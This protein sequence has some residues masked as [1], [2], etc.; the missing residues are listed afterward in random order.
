MAS[1]LTN[2]IYER[3][4]VLCTYSIDQYFGKL[5]L[6]YLVNNYTADYEFMSFYK[7]L[8]LTT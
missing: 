5:Y 4:R 6:L 8:G 1:T 3:E 2:I 7:E